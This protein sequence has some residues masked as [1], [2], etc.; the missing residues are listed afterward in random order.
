MGLE[1]EVR[2]RLW[3]VNTRKRYHDQKR[4]LFEKS[5]V[6]SH[7][8]TDVFCMLVI[9]C[10][11]GVV[12]KKR[13]RNGDGCWAVNTRGRYHDP[14]RELSDARRNRIVSL[15]R[16]IACVIDIVSRTSSDKEKRVVMMVFGGSEHSRRISRQGAQDFWKHLLLNHLLSETFLSRLRLIFYHNRVVMKKRG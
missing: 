9:L 8:F 15:S 1:V 3:A 6:L 12:V 5:S 4:E 13:G 14:K 7:S 2:S 10:R 16:L 11:N